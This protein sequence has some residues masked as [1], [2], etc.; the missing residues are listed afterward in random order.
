MP[1]PGPCG[2]TG[3][4]CDRHP[5]A[6]PPER[7]P[8]H[9]PPFLQMRLARPVPARGPAFSFPGA[10]G[11]AKKLLRT[12]L[13]VAAS[14]QRRNAPCPPAVRP[15]LVGTHLNRRPVAAG[16]PASG[17]PGRPGLLLRGSRRPITSSGC[18]APCREGIREDMAFLPGL[19]DS[20]VQAPKRTLRA[21]PRTGP[22]RQ[23]SEAG[24]Q[25]RGVPLPESCPHVA[26]NCNT[27]RGRPCPL[28]LRHRQ[29]HDKKSFYSWS[30]DAHHPPHCKP[31]SSCLLIPAENARLFE[32]QLHPV[33]TFFA[34]KMQHLHL[35]K[36]FPLNIGMIRKQ[37]RHMPQM[38]HALNSRTD[39]MKDFIT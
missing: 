38:T 6:L 1:L 32:T 25:R 2:L 22:F 12:L 5:V 29:T 23:K 10:S 16:S 35:L 4:A 34:T 30:I 33:A 36:I 37:F 19:S 24:W 17:R 28:L 31:L 15:P 11:P 21:M 39:E 8:Y 3:T 20:P 18:T 26:G 13:S 9:A 27:V 7:A 14:A